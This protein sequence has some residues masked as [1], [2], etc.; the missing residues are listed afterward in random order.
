MLFLVWEGKCHQNLLIQWIL[1]CEIFCL[2][3]R[4]ENLVVSG[5]SLIDL[6]NELSAAVMLLKQMK[7]FQRSIYASCIRYWIWVEKANSCRTLYWALICSLASFPHLSVG[8]IL[9]NSY[10]YSYWLHHRIFECVVMLC[11]FI[12]VCCA[13]RRELYLWI[14]TVPA[15]GCI[16]GDCSPFWTYSLIIACF[17]PVME[18][19]FLWKKRNLHLSYFEIFLDNIIRVIFHI[20]ICFIWDN[21]F[22]IN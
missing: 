7:C 10:I 15:Q 6:T 9:Y 19:W 8:A 5:S 17:M 4:M 16:V 18:I 21:A 2:L 1:N 11:C 22:R 3:L 14:S 20:F 12:L 13:N